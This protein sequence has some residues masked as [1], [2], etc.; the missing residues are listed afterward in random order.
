[1][2][3]HQYIYIYVLKY[4]EVVFDCIENGLKILIASIC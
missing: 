3:A 1:M 4:I 2:F